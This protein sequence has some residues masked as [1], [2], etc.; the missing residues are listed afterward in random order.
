MQKRVG[1]RLQNLKKK[2][3]GFGGKGKLTDRIIDNFQNYYGIAIRSNENNL[4]AMQASQKLLY[5]MLHHVTRTIFIIPIAQ[6]HQTVAASTIKIKLT[7]HR[8]INQ[9]QVFPFQ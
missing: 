6:L 3:K 4:K 5:S 9:A 1:C 7:V 2:E 8:L